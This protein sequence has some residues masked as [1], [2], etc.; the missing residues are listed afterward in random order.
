MEQYINKL[1]IKLRV[2]FAFFFVM[3]IVVAALG[4]YGV[5]PNGICAN[6]ENAQSSYLINVVLIAAA[7]IFSAA[8]LKLFK[9][10]TEQSLKRYTLDDAANAY[11]KWSLIRLVLLF[12]VVNGGLIA[13]FITCDDTGLFVGAIVM[14]LAVIYCIPSISKIKQYLEKSQQQ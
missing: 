7:F 5:I 8:A 14:L 9:L 11:H 12:V 10:N 6:K 3:T 13:Y 2:E 4:F 1:L